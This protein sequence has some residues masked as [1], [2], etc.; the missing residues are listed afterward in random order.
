M[1]APYHRKLALW[2]APRKS[3]QYPSAVCFRRSWRD[4]GGRPRGD[5]FQTL[6]AASSS[7][8]QVWFCLRRC[9]KEAVWGSPGW[10]PLAGPRTPVAS[11]AGRRWMLQH[12]VGEE[13]ISFRLPYV[14]LDLKSF[15]VMVWCAMS[16]RVCIFICSCILLT[17]N[18]V[19]V[20]SLLHSPQCSPHSFNKGCRSLHSLQE[21]RV[22]GI[23]KMLNPNLW[24]LKLNYQNCNEVNIKV[25][26]LAVF[27]LLR[28]LSEKFQMSIA[29]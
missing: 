8:W 10:W 24:W 1:W 4:A 21:E 12:A 3:N 17:G 16:A 28:S 13:D 5:V 20:F 22:K 6:W 9:H 15:F 18:W 2:S 19:R 27:F 14:G 23:L 29:W 7:P 25:E 11:P 26:T